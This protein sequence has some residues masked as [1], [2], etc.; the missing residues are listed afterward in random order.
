MV[1]S[2]LRLGFG[3]P[4]LLNALATHTP[5][6]WTLHPEPK[7]LSLN[8]QPYILHQTLNSL[9]AIR[10]YNPQASIQ[11]SP[12]SSQPR[13]SLLQAEPEGCWGRDQ[14]SYLE[15]HGYP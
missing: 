5:K 6:L 1:V 3:D 11:A 10:P 2:L 14:G 8:P 15:G 9:S 4:S 7:S 12:G 13:L